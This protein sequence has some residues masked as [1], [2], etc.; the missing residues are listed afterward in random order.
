VDRRAISLLPISS[1][2]L[3]SSLLILSA[4]WLRLW[5]VPVRLIR[6]AVG[7]LSRLTL[8]V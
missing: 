3:L 5:S 6:K 7:L 4:Y 8:N 2:Q 1:S